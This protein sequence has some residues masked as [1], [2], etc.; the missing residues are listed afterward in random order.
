MENE[1]LIQFIR[2]IVP[3]AETTAGMIASHFESLQIPKNEF[4][5]HEHQIN[6]R[7]FFVEKGFLRA[8][9]HDIEGNDITTGFYTPNQMAFEVSSFF[10]REPSRENIVALGDCTGRF[11]TYDQLQAL[12]HTIPEFREFGR[13]ILVKGFIAFK[14]RTLSLI[15]ETAEMR[16]ANLLRAQPEILQNVPLKHI[17]S[18]LGMTD[19]SLSRIR[20]QK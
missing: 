18:F 5:L 3:I 1:S 6:D 2:Q 9:T 7:Y 19:T 4:L 12:F 17:A 11:I 16:Y 20:A 13:A 8:F 15:Q 10:L 14:Q